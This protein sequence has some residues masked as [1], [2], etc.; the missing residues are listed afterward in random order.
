MRYILCKLLNPLK[1]FINFYIGAFKTQ[2]SQQLQ[3]FKSFL[4]QYKLRL[5]NQTLI[6]N[7]SNN[8]LITN[9][10]PYT[11]VIFMISNYNLHIIILL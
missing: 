5:Y 1:L 3:R 2:Q 6:A 7:W 9:L 8:Y 4:S 10:K 11:N